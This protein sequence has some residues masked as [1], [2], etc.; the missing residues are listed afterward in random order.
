[1][2]LYGDSRRS[3]ELVQKHKKLTLLFS[4]SPGR[5]EWT[6]RVSYCTTMMKESTAVEKA[7]RKKKKLKNDI[8]DLNKNFAPDNELI[9]LEDSYTTLNN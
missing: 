3:D 6:S 7:N 4:I 5:N 8:C 9:E 2:E 1:M